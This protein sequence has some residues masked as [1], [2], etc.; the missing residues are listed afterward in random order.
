MDC[1]TT[2]LDSYQRYREA[3]KVM[4]PQIKKA[5]FIPHPYPPTFLSTN[6]S[7]SSPPLKIQKL[8]QDEMA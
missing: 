4:N 7:P 1:P 2:C 5:P 3:Q 8:T 6:P